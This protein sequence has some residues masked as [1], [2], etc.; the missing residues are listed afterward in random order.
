MYRAECQLQ[1]VRKDGGNIGILR[2]LR[3]VG[4]TKAYIGT[5]ITMYT[6]LSGP[7]API[8]G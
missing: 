7:I 8:P 6:S 1:G 5:E 4:P 3:Q 2:S